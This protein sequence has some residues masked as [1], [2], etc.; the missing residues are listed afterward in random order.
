MRGKIFL[1]ILIIAALFSGCF[2]PDSEYAR[3]RQDYK[4]VRAQ[5]V[6]NWD[7][8]PKAAQKA[9]LRIDK[10]LVAYDKARGGI[11]KPLASLIKEAK[12][13][14]ASFKSMKDQKPRSSLSAGGKEQK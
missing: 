7:H 9:F 5:I 4:M 1:S 11:L 2:L 6:K 13:I 12:K 3:L 14:R 8:Y 10:A